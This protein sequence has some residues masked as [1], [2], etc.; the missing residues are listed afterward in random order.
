MPYY[1]KKPKLT[2][3]EVMEQIRDRTGVPL[4]GVRKIL[5]AY[6]AL[7]K[8]AL[9]ENVEVPFGEIGYFSWKQI[10]AR[11]DVVTWNPRERRYNEPENIP[12]FQKTVMRINKTWA[13]ELKERTR[14]EY[15]EENPKSL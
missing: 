6:N 10:N 14:F 4:E 12:G 8:E 3:L 11:E 1:P 5:E 13:K 9:L 7:T 2:S 15:G